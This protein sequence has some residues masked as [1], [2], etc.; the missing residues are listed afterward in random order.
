MSIL[1]IF[2]S[3]VKESSNSEELKKKNKALIEDLKLRTEVAINVCRKN[4]EDIDDIIDR[5]KA[6]KVVTD[7]EWEILAQD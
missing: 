3:F 2:D 7:K 5:K 4:I 1:K 6:V